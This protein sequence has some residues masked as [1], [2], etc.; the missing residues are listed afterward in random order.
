MDAPGNAPTDAVL[1]LLADARLP[2]GGHAHSGGLETAAATG[3]VHDLATL[4]AFL[5]GRLA[6]AGLVTAGLAAAACALAREPAGNAPPGRAGPPARTPDG[7]E[8]LDAEA[9]AR[10]PSPAQR[11]ASRAQGRALLRVARGLWPGSVLDLPAGAAGG[12]HH[13][14]VLGAAVAAAGG[15]PVRAAQIAAYGAVTGPASAAVRLLGLDPLGAYRVL[16]GLAAR[17]DA[18]AAEA[19]ASVRAGGLPAAS[20]P[21][22]D[23]FAELHD[24]AGTRLFES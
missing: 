7:W 8:R 11:R 4:T 21:A 3:V 1:L 13:P 24:R 17:V 10:T 23:V 19:A 6:T 5:R 20:A 16:A 12:P 9:D 14:I 15:V 22:L 18:V 2:A